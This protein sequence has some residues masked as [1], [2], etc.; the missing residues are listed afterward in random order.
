MS[1]NYDEEMDEV[2]E[3]AA[4]AIQALEALSTLENQ[5]EQARLSKPRIR[6]HD[7]S[8]TG[9]QYTAE[10]LASQSQVRIM[11]C[12]HMSLPVFTLICNTFRKENLL[13][14]NQFTTVEHQIYIFLYIA[15]TG[16]SNRAAQE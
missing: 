13:Y 1:I 5:S 16:G 11:E 4:I 12:L 9:Q 6:R 2:L 15:A 14:D 3:V 7:S 10:I 8:L